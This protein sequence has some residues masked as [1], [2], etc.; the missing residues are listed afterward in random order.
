MK[1]LICFFFLI[2]VLIVGTASAGEYQIVEGKGVAVCKLCL[3]NLRRQSVEDAICNRHYTAELGLQT[4]EWKKLD[5]LGDRAHRQLLKRVM[6]FVTPPFP[7]G[8]FSFYDD[9]QLFERQVRMES[10]DELTLAL[11]QVDIDNDGNPEPVVKHR[12]HRCISQHGFH[13]SK[14]F[15]LVLTKDQQDIDPA[16]TDQVMQNRGKGALRPAGSVV[17][18]MFEAFVYKGQTYFDNWDNDLLGDRGTFS[19]YRTVGGG[20]SLVCKFRH[21]DR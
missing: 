1:K 6:M 4:V 9:E 10:E 11:A 19:V 13:G 18:Q 20:T 14:Q 2:A 17:K 3:E 21:V 7:K 5:I 8:A 12:R 15:L 16:K